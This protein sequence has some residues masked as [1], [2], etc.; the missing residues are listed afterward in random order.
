M[1][2]SLFL[3][4]IPK[5]YDALWKNRLAVADPEGGGGPT[6]SCQSECPFLC[7]QNIKIFF[8]KFAERNFSFPRSLGWGVVPLS[9]FWPSASS[10]TSK[11][12][13]GDQVPKRPHAAAI[14][15]ECAVVNMPHREYQL[16]AER[17]AT[18]FRLSGNLSWNESWFFLF[19]PVFKTFIYRGPKNN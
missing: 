13:R 8:K 15:F 18:T 11:N 10:K 1:L 17:Q 2:K 16:R 19:N 14:L 6:P 5:S 4:N 9:Q 7:L 3:V 12:S